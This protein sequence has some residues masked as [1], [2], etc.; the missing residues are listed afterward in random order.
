MLTDIVND[1]NESHLART[2]YILYK[3]GPMKSKKCI[4][5]ELIDFYINENHERMVKTFM[6]NMNELIKNIIYD[7]YQSIFDLYAYILLNYIFQCWHNPD[8]LSEKPRSYD[9][10]N[11]NLCRIS[12][13]IQLNINNTRD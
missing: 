3:K 10:D 9:I 11:D 5:D 12:D 6:D 2:A 13:F 4:F 7:D 8:I 1:G